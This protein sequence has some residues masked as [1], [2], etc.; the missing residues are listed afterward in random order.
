MDLI[1]TIRQACQGLYDSTGEVAS[2]WAKEI[3]ANLARIRSNRRFPKIF[4]DPIW[5]TIE[6]KDYEVAFLDSPLLQRLRGIRQ[7][8]M[9]HLVYPGASHDR[10][11]HT[12]GVV[13]VS[14]RIMKALE[15]NAEIRQ[16]YGSDGID[17]PGITDFDRGTTRLAALLHD[18]GHG[19]FSHASEPILNQR[20]GKEIKTAKSEISNWFPGATKIQESE[21]VS[22]MFVLSQPML[23]VF[24]DLTTFISSKGADIAE[25]IAARI[26]GSHKHLTA[27]YLAGTISGPIDADKL[28]YMA[29]DSYYAGLPVGLDV[30][31]LINKLEI[32]AITDKN[33][34]NDDLRNRAKGSPNEC[35]FDIGISL[36]ALN[37][38]EQM[39]VGRI[40]LYDRMYYHHK[41]RSAE[42]MI[43]RLWALTAEESGKPIEAKYL[44]STLSDDAMLALLGRQLDVPNFNAGGTRSR[45]L[46]QAVQCRRLYYRCFAIASRFIKI[47][48]NGKSETEIDDERRE[49]WNEVL[50][51]LSTADAVEG[52]A[53]KIYDL[54][55]QMAQKIPRFAEQ[56]IKLLQEH[57]IIERPKDKLT[58]GGADVLTRTE[59]GGLSAANLYFNPD[60]WSRAYM[61]QRHVDF[62]FAPV[63]FRE[64]VTIAC[65]I[66]FYNR[67][68]L[69]METEAARACKTSKLLAGD[70]KVEAATSGL[71]DDAFVSATFSQPPKLPSS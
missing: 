15:H 46:A 31:R 58:A 30:A 49:L 5:G 71:C 57:V 50:D 40:L 68:G 66:Y 51:E 10:L 14:A 7:L 4:S 19:P 52:L 54:A 55:K 22:V 3:R 60:R 21:L 41:V 8:G 25:A 9:V 35:Y 34:P 37:A 28:D 45:I 17:L 6:L 33:A 39:V 64:L 23:E 27:T 18:I 59:D 48:K 2:S 47:D 70:W 62:V 56:H 61:S 69:V 44:F 63:E 11:S 12:L 43:R 26:V 38:Y 24:E 16:R 36:A 13:E 65:H 53:V 42:C 1:A 67:F 32:I 20:Y 29:R